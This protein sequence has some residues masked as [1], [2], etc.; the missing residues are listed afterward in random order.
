MPTS[1]KMLVRVPVQL[2][3]NGAPHLDLVN[4][5]ESRE[6]ALHFFRRWKEL[7][8]ELPPLEEVTHPVLGRVREQRLFS[9]EVLAPFMVREK[10]ELL[11]GA[12]RGDQKALGQ[13]KRT[14][15]E[16]AQAGLRFKEDQILL[17]IEGWPVIAAAFLTDYTAG[18]I[19]ICAYDGKGCKTPY[20]VKARSTQKF[21]SDS[22]SHL[23]LNEKR[24][25][26]W[27][28]EGSKQRAKKSKKKG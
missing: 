18:R 7:V 8:L 21:C 22:C 25:D 16:S 11:R 6:S 17:E 3:I 15:N 19:G 28:R 20:F 12:W 13:L 14:V 27:H 9:D 5:G 23:G 1:K 26:W 24:L 4:T 10:A 2:K